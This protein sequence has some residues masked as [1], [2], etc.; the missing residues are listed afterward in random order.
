[1][2]R[3]SVNVRSNSLHVTRWR[4][5]GLIVWAVCTFGS[6]GYCAGS[7][8]VLLELRTAETVAAGGPP[9]TTFGILAPPLSMTVEN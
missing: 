3:G 4:L 9:R 7:A 5:G 2:T 8:G 6:G 1:M